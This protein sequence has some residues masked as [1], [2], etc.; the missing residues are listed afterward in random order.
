[1]RWRGELRKV[2]LRLVLGFRG[3]G[4]ERFGEPIFQSKGGAGELVEGDDGGRRRKDGDRVLQGSLLPERYENEAEEREERDHGLGDAASRSA[5]HEA[6]R[7]DRRLGTR[8]NW[9]VRPFARLPSRIFC[10]E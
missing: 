10:C 1:M 4:Y 3:R 2:G 6:D 8:N 7:T 9:L 5:E